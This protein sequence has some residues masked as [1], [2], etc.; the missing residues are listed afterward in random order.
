[1]DQRHVGL[2]ITGTG[3]DRLTAKLPPNGRIA[4]PG[5]YMLFL[6]D[7]TGIPSPAAMIKLT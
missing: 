4:P 3:P 7:A 5:A 1:M 6:I 2:E